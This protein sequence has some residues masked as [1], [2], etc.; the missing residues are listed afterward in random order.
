MALNVPITDAV[1]KTNSTQKTDTKPNN[2]YDKDMFLQL[3]VAE[4]QYQDPL[5]PTSNTEYVSELASFTQIEAVQGAADKMDTL[6]A[7]SLVG[8]YVILLHNDDYVSGK[9]DY[10]MN[11]EDGM[12]LSVNDKLYSIDELDSIYND[13]YYEGVMAATTLEDYV[14][15]LPTISTLTTGDA[16]KVEAARTMYN[17]M[18]PSAKRFVKEDVLK[19]ITNLENRLKFLKGEE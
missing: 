18:D 13:G 3:L 15:Q 7:N 8:K 1:N 2:G 6:Q 9:V 5:E 17:D 14:K 16:A 11:S 10:V 19:A 4:M 12:K